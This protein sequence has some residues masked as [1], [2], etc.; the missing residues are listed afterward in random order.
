MNDLGTLSL[1]DNVRD[2][3]P[4]EDS[5]FTP[6]LAEHADLL[7]GA[8]GLELVH[9]QTEAK[10]G[11]YSADLVFREEGEEE[12]LLVVENMFHASDHDHLGKLITY[13]AWVKARCAVLISPEYREEHRSALKWL[14]SISAGDFHFFGLVLEAWRIDDSR[15]APRLRV[16]VRPDNWDLLIGTGG[17]SETSERGLAYQ[18]FWSEFLPELTHAGWRNR[19]NPGATSSMG[20]G[21]GRKGFS[22]KATFCQLDG[23]KET[24]LRAEMYIDVGNKRLNKEAFDRLHRDREAIEQVAGELVWDRLD[25]WNASRISLY[26]DGHIDVSEHDRWPAA[27]EWLIDAMGRMRKAFTG[28]FDAA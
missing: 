28:K 18:R 12:R 20:F 22:V 2:V 25:D 6:W 7:G 19:R 24:R 4:R 11:R 5:D 1:V 26:Y 9:V 15:P 8:L 16:D 13:A 23:E 27:R 21:S 10:V 17:G 14:N 3:W